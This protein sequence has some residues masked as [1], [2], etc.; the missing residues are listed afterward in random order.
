MSA[1]ERETFLSGCS[2]EVCVSY[3]PRRPLRASIALGTLA[4]AAALG[5]SASAQDPD[6]VVTPDILYF[7]TEDLE[8]VWIGGTQAGDKLQWVDQAELARPDKA[9]LPQISTAEWLPTPK[10]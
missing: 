6:V 7:P 4:A 8:V 9:E 5:G 2:G 3:T 10:G 1:S